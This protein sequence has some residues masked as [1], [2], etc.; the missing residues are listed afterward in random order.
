VWRQ[1]HAG[2]L[3]L[4]WL[5]VPVLFV[6]ALVR[7]RGVGHAAIEAAPVAAIALWAVAV[8][9]H[10]VLSTV[11]TSVGL[12]ASSAALVH[13]SGGLIEMHFHFFVMVG[14]VTLYQ[15][16][17]PFLIAIGSVVVHHTVVGVTD[18]AAVYN[19]PAAIASPWKWA[20]IHAGFIVGMSA[21]GM[22]SWKLNELLLADGA[23]REHK[24][25]EA[26]A[27]ARIG[28][29]EHTVGSGLTTWS[30][31]MRDLLGMTPDELPSM[32]AMYRSLH[33]DDRAATWA[34][35]DRVRTEGVPHDMDCRIVLPDGSVRWVHSRGEAT[36]ED[37]QIVVMSGTIQDITERR[38]S[39]D[40][41]RAREAELHDTLSL[42]NATLESTADGILVVD[43]D[44]R[45][46]SYN[47]R[48]ADMWDLPE[49]VLSEGDD[50]AA[51]AHVL[52]QL[53]DP[54]GFVA[55]VRELYADPEAESQDTII[56]D[57]GRVVERFSMPS[58]S[59][60]SWSAECGASTTSPTARA[61]SVSSHIRRSTTRSPGSRTSS[62]S[63]TGSTTPSPVVEAPMRS[64][65]SSSTST[66]SRM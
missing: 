3:V 51:L 17:R 66:T 39:E 31:G 25:A 24:L 6:M 54:D 18:P 38:Q 33:P 63:A 60:G 62:S 41:L 40:E 5:H 58:G 12:M 64:P 8:D 59:V 1:R 13:L 42:L 53:R 26:H 32:R 43:V 20:L 21:T 49:H 55:K 44:G 10:T 56:F 14:V 11:L 15:D 45:I 22:V 29:W 35:M 2:I 36:W 48:F 7:G 9:R 46:T 16:W 47:G 57:D 23:K 27:M 4:L 30:D 19:H 37:G 61:S 52:S 50:D 34:D 28:S 65:S